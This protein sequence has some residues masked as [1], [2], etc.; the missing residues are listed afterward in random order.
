MRPGYLPFWIIVVGTLLLS[1]NLL[2]QGDARGIFFWLFIA[3][4]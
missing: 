4:R 3:G 1:L 2:E